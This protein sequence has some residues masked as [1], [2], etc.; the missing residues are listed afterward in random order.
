MPLNLHVS[1][2][3]LENH[4]VTSVTARSLTTGVIRYSLVGGNIGMAFSINPT[5]GTIVVSHL[6]DYEMTQTFRLWVAAQD[7]NAAI[8]RSYV[9][10]VIEID[11]ENDNKPRFDQMKYYAELLEQSPLYSS[12]VKVHATDKDSGNN[13]AVHYKFSDSVTNFNLFSINEETGLI[14]TGGKLDREVID[15]YELVVEAYDKVSMINS[16]IQ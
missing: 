8:Q 10:V 13:G 14:R 11:D 16:N 12:V 1:E 3:A 9:E 4:V 2:N 15:H 7:G 6:L 5:T